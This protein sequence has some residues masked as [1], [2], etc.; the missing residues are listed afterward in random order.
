MRNKIHKLRTERSKNEEKITALRAR[1]SELDKQITELENLDIVGMVRSLGM[2]PEQL[3]ALLNE[4]GIPT[5][6][7]APKEELL[8]EE[9]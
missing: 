9:Q 7:I 5:P 3:A 2:T 8:Y 1:N 4:T 6:E